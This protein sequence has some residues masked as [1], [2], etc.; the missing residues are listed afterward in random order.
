MKDIAVGQ[1]WSFETDK[2]KENSVL[3]H[4]I[5]P[6][7]DALTVVHITLSEDV[8]VCDNETMSFGHFPFESTAFKNSLHELLGTSNNG[9]EIFKEGYEYWKNQNGGIFTISIHDAIE[10][11]V[12][13][14]LNPDR[15]K[16][17]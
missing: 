10:M 6:F 14:N 15:V 9:Q 1:L 12:E 5:E 3:I 17:E 16:K 4:H 8:Q 7:V 13:T 2:F 11:I